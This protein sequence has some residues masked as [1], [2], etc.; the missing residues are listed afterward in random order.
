[1]SNRHQ[2]GMTLVELV[3][4][5]AI[6]GVGLAGVLG[7]LSKLAVTTADP[8][9]KK[10]MIAIAEGMLE[11]VQLQPYTSA[12]TVTIGANSCV[13]DQFQGTWDYNNYNAPRPICDTSGNPITMLSGYR[14]SVAVA[15]EAAGG[16]LTGVPAGRASRITVTVTHG[17]DNYSLQ[18]WRVDY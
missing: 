13:R 16:P 14:V 2:R 15:N 11:E 12:T 17:T 9:I 7:A 5:M 10:Q 4:A 3:I 1:M 8:L 6:I 18:G